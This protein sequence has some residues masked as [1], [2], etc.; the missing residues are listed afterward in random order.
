[1]LANLFWPDF[2]QSHAQANLRRSLF[3]LNHAIHKEIL[4]PNAGSIGI[5]EL[6]PTWVDVHEFQRLVGSIRSHEH[7]DLTDCQDCLDRLEQAAGLYRGDFLAGLNLPDCPEFDEW[8]YFKREELNQELARVLEQLASGYAS[9]A[10]WERAIGHARRWVSLDRLNEPAHRMLMSLYNQSGQRSAS[11]RQYENLTQLLQAEFGQ[12]PEPE[13]VEL[14]EQVQAGEARPRPL[15]KPLPSPV[16][17]A[18]GNE[19]LIKTKLLIPPLRVERIPRSRLLH[20]V[21]AGC[22]RSLTLISA[23]AGFGKTTLLAHWTTNTQLPVAWYS[24][25]ESDNDPIRFLSYLIAAIDSVIP[26][27]AQ[28]FQG[29]FQSLQPSVEPILIGLVNHLAP[30]RDPFVLILDDYHFIHSPDVHRSLAFLLE[31]I[32]PCIHIVLA[33]RVDPA[34]PL[35]RLRARDQLIEIRAN[36]LR[37]TTDETT[38]FLKRVMSLELTQGDISAL[39]MRTEGWIAGLQMAALALR[40]MIQ[41]QLSPVSATDHAQKELSGFIQAFSGSNRYILDYLGEEVLNNLPQEIKR[42][43]LQ[44]SILKRLSGPLCD[45]VTGTTIS[46]A[47]LEELEKSNLFLIPLDEERCWYRYHHLFQE[48]LRY[49]AEEARLN[50][51]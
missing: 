44:T 49:Q 7:A 43:L 32:P 13:T 41:P 17:S 5:N 47:V 28:P 38:D 21:D 9:Q 4:V 36:D 2:D 15:E 37:F 24:L 51:P 42:F 27:F 35:A 46:Q 26:G 3:S 8:Q 19:P 12:S 25:D 39:S 1:M 34:L 50:D 10:K 29:A 33:T 22:Q 16:H 11:I 48:L 31:K 14:Y 30:V 40:S 18:Q 6:A 23:P 45:A 20:L